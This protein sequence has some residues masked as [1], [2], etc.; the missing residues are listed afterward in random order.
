MD[1]VRLFLGGSPSIA[2]MVIGVCLYEYPIM[3]LALVLQP[4]KYN[5]KHGCACIAFNRVGLTVASIVGPLS[6]SCYWKKAGAKQD[7]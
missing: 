2:L 4:N 7:L 6:S 1:F 3:Q 5:I